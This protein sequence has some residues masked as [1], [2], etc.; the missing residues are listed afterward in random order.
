MGV[1]RNTPQTERHRLGKND[2][3][4]SDLIYLANVGVNG[5]HIRGQYRCENAK[6]E[7]VRTLR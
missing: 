7:L 6:S 3:L 2:S 1:T 5:G 4:V